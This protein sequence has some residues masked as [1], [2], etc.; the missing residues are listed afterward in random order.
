MKKLG[1]LTLVLVAAACGGARTPA[2]PG[3]TVTEIIPATSALPSAVPSRSAAATIAPTSVS[4]PAAATTT[5]T[6]SPSPAATPDAGALSVKIISPE[7]NAVVTEAQVEING[8][9]A[10]NA[11]ITLNDEIAVADVTGAF[12]ARLSLDEGPNVIE[13]VASDMDGHETDLFLT[14]TYEPAS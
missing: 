13:I 11:V 12:T 2:S 1:L 3:S 6:A 14:I 5:P 8:Q 9:T 7:D 10:P 4:S